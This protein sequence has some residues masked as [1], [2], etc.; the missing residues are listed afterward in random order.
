[1]IPPP[2]F[3]T[4][5]MP[6]CWNALKLVAFRVYVGLA[7]GS[8][9][10]R[11]GTPACQR[12]LIWLTYRWSSMNQKTASIS[13]FSLSISD[14]SW[15]RQFWKDGSQSVSAACA[16]VEMPQR[17]TTAHAATAET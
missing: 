16:R 3:L 17:N 14:N 8:T 1:M 5:G 4:I 2:D 10:N 7:R 13:T 6:A 12:A 11:T 9:I 15:V